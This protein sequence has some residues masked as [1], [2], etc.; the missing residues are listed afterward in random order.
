MDEFFNNIQFINEVDK[1][2]YGKDRT[3]EIMKEIKTYVLAYTTSFHY[4]FKLQLISEIS[5]IN[6]KYDATIFKQIIFS[7][8]YNVL[9]FIQLCLK[10]VKGTMKKEKIEVTNDDGV[11]KKDKIYTINVR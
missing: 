11:I 8:L 6:T 7:L 5:S 4:K 1:L 9:Y 2:P 3:K 10:S